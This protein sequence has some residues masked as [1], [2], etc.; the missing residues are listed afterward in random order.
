MAVD[1]FVV[2]DN[3]DFAHQSWQN[4]NRIKGSQGPLFLSV[5]VL[6]K[7]KGTQK[8]R[9]VLIAP[10]SNYKEKHLKSIH[11]NYSN[12]PFFE[13][14]FS[15]LEAVYAQDHSKLIDLNLEIIR[16]ICNVLEI[17]TPFILGSELKSTGKKAAL[18]AEQVKEIGGTA[19]LAAASSVEYVR[20]ESKFEEYGIKVEFQKFEHP[21]YSQ[22]H[23]S[24]LSH[25]SII[26]LIMNLGPGAHQILPHNKS[27]LVRDVL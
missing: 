27:I 16:M 17:S 2:L 7:G 1:K 14:F 23:G 10:N 24:F 22:L 15:Q 25:L 5:P 12:A 20:S 9:E 8:I 4:R 11:H 21:I 18:S 13:P 3:V 6:T 19:F 26:D